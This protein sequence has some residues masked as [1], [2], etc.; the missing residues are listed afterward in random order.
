MLFP[1]N[2]TTVVQRVGSHT[3]HSW[4]KSTTTSGSPLF[5]L[6]RHRPPPLDH[7]PRSKKILRNVFYKIVVGEG[8]T[9]CFSDQSSARRGW[10]HARL[11]H[12]VRLIPTHVCAAPLLWVHHRSIRGFVQEINETHMRCLFGGE[13]FE[14][15]S[16]R[17]HCHL[18]LHCLSLWRAACTLYMVVRVSI[19]LIDYYV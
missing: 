17:R 10:I 13:L 19:P 2:I 4:P 1:N 12:F 15:F 5:L 9:I 18:T 8:K 14:H 11:A 6:F 3:G 7:A 16:L